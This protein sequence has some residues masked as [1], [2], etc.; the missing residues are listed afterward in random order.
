[1]PIAPRLNSATDQA[2][3]LARMVERF[4]VDE[5]QLGIS[6][7]CEFDRDETGADSQNNRVCVVRSLAFGRASGAFRIHV[8]VETGVLDHE[9]EWSHTIDKVQIPW[10]SC[11]RE[12]KLLAFEKLPALLDQIIGEAERLTWV[13]DLT[14]AKVEKMTSHEEDFASGF[15]GDGLYTASDAARARHQYH[16]DDGTPEAKID[17]WSMSGWTDDGGDCFTFH[18]DGDPREKVICTVQFLDEEGNADVTFANGEHGSV[19][20]RKG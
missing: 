2:S 20:I 15:G 12:T 10:P 8:A 3:K 11:D 14:V 7:E 5:L 16:I 1:M 6:A 19:N 13:A 17:P 4:L 9:G 18:R